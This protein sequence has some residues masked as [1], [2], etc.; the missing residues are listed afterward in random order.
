VNNDPAGLVNILDLLAVVNWL[1]RNQG[2]S[3]LPPTG[4]P[5]ASGYVD[6]N[7]DGVC[8]I[9]DLLAVVNHIT[10]QMNSGG[11][12]GEPTGGDGLAGQGGAGAGE[13]ESLWD[14]ASAAPR[15]NAV[16]APRNA[17]EYYAEEP[18][19][20]LEIPGTDLPCCCG[21]CMAVS[22]VES[23]SAA[24]AGGAPLWFPADAMNAREHQSTLGRPIARR[25]SPLA[26]EAQADR[27]LSDLLGSRQ[28]WQSPAS[29]G[30]PIVR[31]IAL[32]AGADAAEVSA[33]GELPRH[34]RRRAR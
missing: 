23:A 16:Y 8:N 22:D 11:G 10:Q 15:N 13:G 7:N 1:V 20:L 9:L 2:N 25:H 30:E 18:F 14:L 6:V 17:A 19:H 5:Q 32:S 4:D 12:E 31:D 26:T 27:A 28:S 29:A 3:A 21:G 33:A 24:V 34:L